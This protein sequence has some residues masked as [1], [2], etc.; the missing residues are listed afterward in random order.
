MYNLGLQSCTYDGDF[1]CSN[2]G[3]VRSYDVC[4]YHC[5]CSDCSDEYNCSKYIKCVSLSMAEYC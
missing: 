1:R 5:D 2:G 4:N 3:C